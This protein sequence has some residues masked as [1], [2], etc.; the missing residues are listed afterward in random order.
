MISAIILFNPSTT[1]YICWSACYQV[2]LG[3][4]FALLSSKKFLKSE[5]VTDTK[6]R[7]KALSLSIFFLILSLSCYQTTVT[8]FF[9]PIFFDNKKNQLNSKT[10]RS[11]IVFFIGLVTYFLIF[12]I[13]PYL[14]NINASNRSELVS[15]IL[16]KIMFFIKEPLINATNIVYFP[17]E[18]SKFSLFASSINIYAFVIYPIVFSTSKSKKIYSHIIICA[19]FLVMS[20]LP[21]LLITK[22]GLVIDQQER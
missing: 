12:K 20:Y 5:E 6:S 19:L 2:G 17:F 16:G 22:I 13:S 9:I 8:A 4:I 10:L 14:L 18:K 3:F 11:I 7:I 15:D 1:L 21:Q